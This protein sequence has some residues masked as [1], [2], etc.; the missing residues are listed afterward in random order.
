[1]SSTTHLPSA[2]LSAHILDTRRYAAFCESCGGK[3][4]FIHHEPGVGGINA[5]KATLQAYRITFKASFVNCAYPNE[6]FIFKG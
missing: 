4:A 3:G 1:M 6:S 5:Y 2:C